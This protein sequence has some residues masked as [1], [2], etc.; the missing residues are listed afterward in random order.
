MVIAAPIKHVCAGTSLNAEHFLVPSKQGI[1]SRTVG[2][3]DFDGKAARGEAAGLLDAAE[4]AKHAM[5]PRVS[6]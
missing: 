1:G 4:T 5:K 6:N 2:A 3:A